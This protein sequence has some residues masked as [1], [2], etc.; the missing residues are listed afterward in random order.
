MNPMPAASA[1]GDLRWRDVAAVEGTIRSVRSRPWADQVASLECT[2]LDTTGGI[3]LVFLG[4]RR[5][6]G[7]QLGAGIR[8][9]GRIG[10]HHGRL[11]ILNPVYEL[12]SPSDL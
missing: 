4:R 9:F 12:M 3:E 11:A 8:A 5:L 2:V 6:G 7:V 10:A 1:I